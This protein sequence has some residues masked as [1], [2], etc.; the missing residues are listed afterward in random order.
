MAKVHIFFKLQEVKEK[1][2]TLQ[3]HLFKLTFLFLPSSLDNFHRFLQSAVGIETFHR[4]KFK[5][6]L[7]EELWDK[8]VEE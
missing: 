5:K 2:Y 1:T 4:E 7:D 6:M 3:T 8:L